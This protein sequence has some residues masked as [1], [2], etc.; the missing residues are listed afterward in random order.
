V[1]TIVALVLLRAAGAYLWAERNED[2]L[3]DRHLRELARIGRG[4]EGQAGRFA[5]SRSDAR[6]ARVGLAAIGRLVT[7]LQRGAP[8]AEAKGGRT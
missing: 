4:V 2:R 5:R 6:H 3:V 7:S 8:A 1:A